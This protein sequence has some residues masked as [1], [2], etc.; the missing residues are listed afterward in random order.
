MQKQTQSNS[1][2][3][4]EAVTGWTAAQKSFYVV[5]ELAGVKTVA[6]NFVISL[7]AVSFNAVTGTITTSISLSS[8]PYIESIII[9][10]ILIDKT[11]SITYTPFSVISGSSAPY[12]FI[13]IDQLAGG[14]ATLAGNGFSSS[15]SS[16]GVTCVGA[17]CPATCISVALCQGYSGTLNANGTSCLICGSGQ[18]QIN[19]QCITPSA[20]GNNQ[21]YS[22]TTC[23]CYSGYI[24]VSNICYVTC[25]PNAY[26]FNSQCSCIPGYTYSPSANQCVLQNQIVCGTNFVAINNKCVCANGYGLLNNQCVQCP[27]NSY[28][29]PS[30]NCA[31]VPGYTINPNTRT[32]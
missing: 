20:C 28:V 6:S 12:Q 22:G 8:T 15:S 26:V 30:G 4:N 23:I 7:T 27:F 13:G 5:V 29:D 11:S 14:S 10:Y 18:N 17:G 24:M 32:C 25:G 9:T 31:C 3:W 21:Y 1:I 19:G 2:I 16:S